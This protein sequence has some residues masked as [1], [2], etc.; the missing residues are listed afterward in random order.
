MEDMYINKYLK[1]LKT[2][3]T[4]KDKAA[5]LNKIYEDGFEDGVNSSE[6]VIVFRVGLKEKK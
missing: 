5:I 2:A 1:M 4:T 3:K 6:K